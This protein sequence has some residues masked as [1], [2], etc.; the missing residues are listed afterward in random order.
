MA[1]GS[2]VFAT[3]PGQW[4]DLPEVSISLLDGKYAPADAARESFGTDYLPKP[5]EAARHTTAGRLR[6][7]GFLVE[8]T[9]RLPGSPNHVSVKW[10]G[11]WTEDVGILFDRCFDEPE[12]R[13]G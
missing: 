9:P 2:F 7:Q 8:L 1:D 10:S 4:R 6:D 3:I 5:R 13:R 12:G 11:E